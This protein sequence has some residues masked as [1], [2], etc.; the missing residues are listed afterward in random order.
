MVICLVNTQAEFLVETD[1]LEVDMAY[2][3]VRGGQF[4]EV[5][6]AQHLQDESKRTYSVC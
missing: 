6:F 3:R 1:Y 4:R 5:V 2:K